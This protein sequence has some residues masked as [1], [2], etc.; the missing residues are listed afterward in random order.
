AS[1]PVRPYRR[2]VAGSLVADHLVALLAE[3]ERVVSLGGNA[4][5][6]AT[7]PQRFAG[8]P[9]FERLNDVEA[10]IALAPDLVVVNNFVHA[11]AVAQ[12]RNAGLEVFDL[13]EMH[14]LASFVEDAR[15]LATLI[16]APERGERFAAA[17]EARMRGVAADIPVSAR[18][19]AMYLGTHGALFFG[20]T[21]GTSYH[22]VLVHGGLLDVAA[23]R[24]EG[25]PAFTSEQILDLD[26][27]VLVTSAG[28]GLEICRRAGL[29]MLRPCRGDGRIIELPM[30]LLVDPGA[31]MLEAAE[32]VRRK[33]HGSSQAPGMRE[34]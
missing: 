24:Y 34:R 30:E 10:L 29:D 11:G 33:V 4:L 2:I 1:V 19:R 14:G 22:E 17:F 31:A 28:K 16:D 25:W 18:P 6:G 7:D 3:R 23:E 8:F 27:D 20:G 32:E 15:Q 5:A 13:G 21:R 26:P 9:T 12:L